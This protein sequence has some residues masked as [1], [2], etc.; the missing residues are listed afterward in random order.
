MWSR[1]R[2][3]NRSSREHP[4]NTAPFLHLGP[5]RQFEAKAAAAAAEERVR[6]RA[7]VL[8]L[9]AELAEARAGR[10]A[11]VERAVEL[12]IPAGEAARSAA[13]CCGT[14]TVGFGGRG[15]QGQR[16]PSMAFDGLEPGDSTWCG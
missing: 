12:E 2:I 8:A 10:A 13:A 15:R 7:V 16:V 9:E 3:R 11:A 6:E 4:P 14:V 5:L 1:T